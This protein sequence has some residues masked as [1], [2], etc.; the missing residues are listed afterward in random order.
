MSG[1]DFVNVFYWA[2]VALLWPW[3]RF[4]HRWHFHGLDQVPRSGGV[5]I[6]SNHISYLDPIALGYLG[7][8]L[9]RPVRFL[10]KSELFEKKVAGV[11]LLGFLL[12]ALGQIRVERGTKEASASLEGA[13]AAIR[14]GE[15]V[16]VFPEGTISYETFEPMEPKTGTARIAA[17]TGAPVVPVAIW[18]S[19]RAMTK[20]RK[21]DWKPR[22]DIMVYC[23]EPMVAAPDEDI[24][25]FSERL[26]KQISALLDDAMIA[27]PVEPEAGDDWWLPPRLRS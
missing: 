20:H 12:G 2:V 21:P 25:E 13:E 3:A 5:V 24:R 23:G 4:W 8:R 27:Y 7:L 15:V 11:K 10:A 19:H 9:R 26:M 14:K 6:A 16:S 18:G 22:K 17:A 1:A